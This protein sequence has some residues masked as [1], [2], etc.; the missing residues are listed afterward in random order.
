MVSKKAPKGKA[1]RKSPAKRKPA[2]KKKAPTR[3]KAAPKRKAP[4]RNPPGTNPNGRPC[5]LT[6]EVIKTAEAYLHNFKTKHKHAIPS[7]V[8]LAKVLNITRT[9]I[10]E[11]AK[12][13]EKD[14]EGRFSYIVE[15]LDDYQE[16]ELIQGGLDGTHNPTI[17]K[18][19]LHK[20]G[21]SD[22]VEQDVNAHLSV[23]HEEWL[24]SLEDED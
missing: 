13:K 6:P 15:A 18:L 19:L 12:N 1:P 8:G 10:Y 16:F 5:L 20:H 23:S 22:K 2:A 9:T 21:H 11:W 7:V 14:P 3:R 17:S 4:K 24:S